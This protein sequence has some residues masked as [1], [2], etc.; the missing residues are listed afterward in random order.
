VTFVNME[1][2]GNN[3]Y[4]PI[5][6]SGGANA[7][8][9]APTTGGYSGYEGLLFWQD[10]NILSGDYTKQNTVSGGSSTTLQGAL[11]F[12][13]SPLYY[14]GGSTG[15]T[16]GYTLIV[17]DKINFSGSATLGHDF[18]SLADGSPIKN[19]AILSE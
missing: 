8:L 14:S 13:D 1:G 9:S 10:H 17:A 15:T 2:A 4:K 12:P 18:S 7:Q 16:T 11:Y 6:I 19:F 5:V 3:G